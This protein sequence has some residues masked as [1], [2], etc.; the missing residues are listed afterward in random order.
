MG[1]AVSTETC[2]CGDRSHRLVR[3]PFFFS[4]ILPCSPVEMLIDHPLPFCGPG[5]VALGD[6]AT[7]SHSDR[8]PPLDLIRCVHDSL[9]TI[10]RWDYPLLWSDSGSGGTHASLWCLGSPCTNI[11]FPLRP[12]SYGDVSVWRPAPKDP[13]GVATT[14]FKSDW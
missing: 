11:R 7:N 5:F 9:V 4:F 6:I 1:Q 13:F 3:E 2:L 12:G 8:K 14:T 10:G